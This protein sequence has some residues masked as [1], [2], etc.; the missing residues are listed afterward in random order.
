MTGLEALRADSAAGAGDD[1][2]VSMLSRS[3]WPAL[4]ALI[5]LAFVFGSF[6]AVVPLLMAAVAIP[7]TFLLVWPL[8]AVTDV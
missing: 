6:M 3:W 5:V 2:S 4:G 8:T 7:T 1:T